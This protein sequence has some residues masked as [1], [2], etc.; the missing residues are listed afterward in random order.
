MSHTHTDTDTSYVSIVILQPARRV[1]L[2]VSLDSHCKQ[3][4]FLINSFNTPVFVV[5]VVYFEVGT[6]FFIFFLFKQTRWNF[7]AYGGTVA[8][9]EV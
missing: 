6:V 8:V 9:I 2:R 1:Y 5:A 3:R 7:S 4:I